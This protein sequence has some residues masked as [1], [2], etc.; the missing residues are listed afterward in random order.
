M[1]DRILMIHG[2]W[3]GAWYWENYRQFFE[4]AGYACTIPDLRHHGGEPGEPPHADLGTTSLLDYAA[5]LE[6]LARSFDEPPIVMGHSMGGL[7]A[8][9]LAARGVAKAAVLLT[10]A[11]P[12]G[13]NALKLSVLWSFKGPL[14]Q[15]GFWK[16][17]N[18]LSF[19]AAAFA[20]LHLM[21]EA[22]QRRL[23]GKMGYESGRAAFEIG[24]WP[25][26]LKRA[27]WVDRKK[28][29]CPVLIVA[30]AEDRITP[31]S[32][33]RK[34]QSKYRKVSTYMEFPGHA[35]W[36]VGEPGWETITAYILKWLKDEETI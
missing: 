18:R 17:A 31:A 30:G 13:I 24:F 21:P 11:S 34:I 36:V 16:K 33:I 8:Q 29:T 28:V 22:E 19:G 32:V 15:W 5:D 27:S 2:M 3:G 14:S 10:P 9:M 23:H 20:T 25:F 26:D 12:W 7:L 35:H 4:A 6:T 1:T